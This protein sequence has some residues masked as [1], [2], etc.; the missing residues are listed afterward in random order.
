MSSANKNYIDIGYSATLYVVTRLENS[1][2]VTFGFDHNGMKDVSS[3][4]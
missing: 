3:Q 1:L 2:L 4:C